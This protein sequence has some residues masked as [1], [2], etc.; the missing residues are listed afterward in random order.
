M[1]NARYMLRVARVTRAI[2]AHGYDRRIRGGRQLD[3]LLLAISR[4][5]QRKSQPS[6]RRKSAPLWLKWQLWGAA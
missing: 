6:G 3:R 2:R 4:N 1:S 5:G